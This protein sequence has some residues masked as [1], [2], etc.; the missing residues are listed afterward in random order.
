M[1]SRVDD[2]HP[3]AEQ[4]L[5]HFDSLMSVLGYEPDFVSQDYA[6]GPPAALGNYLGQKLIDYGLQDGANESN[7]YAN[8]FYE[9]VNPPL[10]PAEPG[11]PGIVD[12]DRWQPLS[13]RRGFVDQSGNLIPGDTTEFLS[14]EWGSVLPFALSTTDLTIYERNGKLYC[15][16]HDPGPPPSLVK[17]SEE[18]SEAYK[19]GFTLVSIWASQLDPSDGVVLDISPASIGNSP[20]LPRNFSDY[21]SF[22]DLLNGLCDRVL[23][24][25]VN[26][27]KEEY[28]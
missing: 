28:A 23:E 19:W 3:G 7:A 1:L 22:F 12:L 15:V 18:H 14:P 5:A 24:K 10:V 2:V 21:D 6:T 25:G 26:F 8:R 27:V 4:S 20:D 17:M 16:Y 11:A 9:P 13:L